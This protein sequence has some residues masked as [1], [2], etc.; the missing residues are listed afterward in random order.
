MAT[1]KLEE[2]PFPNFMDGDQMMDHKFNWFLPW[3]IFSRYDGIKIKNPSDK[4]IY[5][6]EI[7]EPKN[8]ITL[9]ITSYVGL[10]AGAKHIYG[11]LILPKINYVDRAKSNEHHK[12]ST[13]YIKNYFIIHKLQLNRIITK[14][15]IKNNPDR[16]KTLDEAR[17]IYT[18]GFNDYGS[19][20]K[21]AKTFFKE[22]FDGFE[23]EV[24]DHT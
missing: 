7:E 3:N 16:F 11:Q 22:H 18:H 1:Q 2:Y 8:R 19:L 9:D 6:L 15:E 4:I 17:I 10:S 24:K 21:K 5:T 20:R 13:L 14:N 12:V 23:L